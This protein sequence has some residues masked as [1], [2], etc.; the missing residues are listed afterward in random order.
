MQIRLT[1]WEKTVEETYQIWYTDHE[2]SFRSEFR[3]RFATEDACRSYLYRECFPQ[4]FICPKCGCRGF[5]P[6]RTRHV[7]PC[8]SCRR[9][10]SVTAGTVMHRTRLPLTT[11]FW[12]IYL[13]AFVLRINAASQQRHL[14]ADWNYPISFYNSLWECYL[15]KWKK[16]RL[17][18]LFS[19]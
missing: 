4:G 6:V 16:F 7:C 1:K 13:C 11:W 12:A 17:S 10:T 9:Q 3:K 18:F 8:K 5:Y 14:P 19:P 15:W 2:I